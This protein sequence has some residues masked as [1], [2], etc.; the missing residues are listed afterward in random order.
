MAIILDCAAVNKHRR[1]E[2]CQLEMHLIIIS[3]KFYVSTRLSR[4]MLLCKIVEV[5]VQNRSSPSSCRIKES[6]DQLDGAWTLAA[7]AGCGRS[8]IPQ[9][10][11][12]R[13]DE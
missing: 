11:G 13:G 2:L 12:G 7:G 1:Q 9:V 6:S 10:C 4:V 8:T 3:P 5:F